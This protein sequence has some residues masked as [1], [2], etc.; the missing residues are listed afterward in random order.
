MDAIDLLGLAAGT[1]TTC[2]FSPQGARTWRTRS[3]SDI[4]LAMFLLFCTGVLLWLLYGIAIES[5]PVI[6]ANAVTLLLGLMI[7][8]MKLSF[9]RSRP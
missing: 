2:S 6:V 1:L 8:G 3:A 5:L 7:L 9:D 4:S